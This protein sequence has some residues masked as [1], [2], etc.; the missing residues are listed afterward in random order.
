VRYLLD[1]HA[2]L[3]A[4]AAPEKLSPKARRICEQTVSPLFVSVASLW[5]LAA[6]CGAG[7]L[8]IPQPEVTLPGWV[9]RMNMQVLS[10]EA[11][12]V[13]AVYGLPMLHKDPFDRMLIV[14][15]IAE[16]LVLVTKDE[17]IHRYD[18]KW[19]W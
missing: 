1:S 10:L 13:Y 19:A 4:A 11:A 8:S 12:H 7:K 6:K 15:A 5:E 14:Q 18:V 17:D 3:W 2:F 9:A 16:G